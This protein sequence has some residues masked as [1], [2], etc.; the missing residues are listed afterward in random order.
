LAALCQ[1]RACPPAREREREGFFLSCEWENKRF[2]SIS[3]KLLLGMGAKQTTTTTT[4]TTTRTYWT[5]IK[6]KQPRWRNPASICKLWVYI[7]EEN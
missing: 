1:Y 5:T 4:T 3:I 6:A 2:D 7:E